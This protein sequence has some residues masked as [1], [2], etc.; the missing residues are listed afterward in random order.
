M[1]F[2]I[3]TEFTTHVFSTELLNVVYY[4]SSLIS[5]VITTCNTSSQPGDRGPLEGLS[6]LTGWGAA[7]WVRGISINKLLYF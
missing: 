3:M 5:A 1:F 6:K 4:K 7:G 2:A